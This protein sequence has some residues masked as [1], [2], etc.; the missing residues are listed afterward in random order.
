M[1]KRMKRKNCCLMNLLRTVHD[2][3][4]CW[5]QKKSHCWNRFSLFVCVVGVGGELALLLETMKD[6]KSSQRLLALWLRERLD[7]EFGALAQCRASLR[8]FW[9][10]RLLRCHRPTRA[11]QSTEEAC[12]LEP[13]APLQRFFPMLLVF[14]QTPPLRH[15]RKAPL[16]ASDCVHFCFRHLKHSLFFLRDESVQQCGRLCAE[17]FQRALASE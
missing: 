1:K 7:V 16:R 17:A 4:L 12:A 8:P 10:Q 2:H 13:L 6:P 3:V 9:G 11:K 5:V 14:L 15:H